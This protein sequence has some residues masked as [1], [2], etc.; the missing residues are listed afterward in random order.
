MTDPSAAPANL[1]PESGVATEAKP[2]KQVQVV[3]APPVPP[4][5]P[6]EQKPGE[7]DVDSEDD[8]PDS[9]GE[10]DGEKNGA[11]SNGKE[12]NGAD[13]VD[14]NGDADVDEASLLSEFADDEEVSVCE[15]APLRFAR[16]MRALLC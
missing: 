8:G 4:P 14:A 15:I 7:E 6:R 16:S 9:E 1:A 3:G 10:G 2:R 12:A 5:L 13:T 11:R